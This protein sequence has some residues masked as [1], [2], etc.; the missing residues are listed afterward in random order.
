MA[1]PMVVAAGVSAAGSLLAG[2]SAMA[3]G[4]YQQSVA[5]QNAAM[6]EMRAD[7][8]YRI[9]LNNVK[10][11]EQDYAF[12]D[13]RTQMAYMKAGVKISEGTPMDVLLF[14]QQQAEIAKE[15]IMYDAEVDSYEY[16]VAAVNNRIQGNMAM[17][18]A[19]QQ[20]SASIISAF[21][22]MVGAYATQNMITSTA[23]KNAELIKTQSTMTEQLIKQ[24]STNQ[25]LI[26]NTLHNNNINILDQINKNAETL[27]NQGY[28]LG[29]KHANETAGF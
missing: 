18:Q 12:E 29:L 23:A 26:M 15:N 4:R 16:K 2:Q 13:A 5:E 1:P 6:N 21:G 8:A 3:A 14:Q 11:F 22:T 20:R 19:R 25:K 17:F 9:G 10:K 7:D 28:D 27:I 24:Q